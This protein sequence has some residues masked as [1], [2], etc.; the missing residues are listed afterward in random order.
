M[1]GL[2]RFYVGKIFRNERRSLPGV[3]TFCPVSVHRDALYRARCEQKTNERYPSAGA[4]DR[5]IWLVD[6]TG[7]F[8]RCVYEYA[9]TIP[10]RIMVKYPYQR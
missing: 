2:L 1:D 4:F 5:C 6:L 9:G 8:G 10:A 3:I 7:A